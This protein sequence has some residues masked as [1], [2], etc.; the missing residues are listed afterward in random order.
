M[1]NTKKKNILMVIPWMEM[2]GADL[3]NLSIVEKLNKEMFSISIVCT[4]Q[5][6]NHWK[7]YFEKYVKDIHILP[8]ILEREE[9]SQY[10]LD[11][12]KKQNIDIVFLSNS[13]YGYHLLP[14]LKCTYPQVAVVDYVHMEEWYWRK[15]GYARLSGMLEYCVDQT[16]V[17]NQRTEKVLIDQFGRSPETV[18][19]LYIGVDQHRFDSSVVPRGEVR[20]K[21]NIPDDKKVI[22]FPCRIH[23][24][25]RPLLMLEIAKQVI[26][27]NENVCFFVAGDGPL[28]SELIKK[29]KR[30]KLNDWFICPGEI[31][32]MEKVYADS[33]L[34]L[35]CSLKEGLALTAYESC[36]MSTPV[37]S[38]DVGGQKELI[39]NT[40]GRLV[41]L[42][43]KETDIQTTEYSQEEI[44]AYTDAI[45]EVLED[46]VQYE[47]MCRNCRQKIETGF[48]TDQMI[49][50]LERILMD[51]WEMVQNSSQRER[52]PKS[53]M[54]WAQHYLETYLAYEEVLDPRGGSQ[55]INTELKRIAD[56]RL[57][58]IIIKV[59]L[60]L[61][62]NK[63]FR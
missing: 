24:Q 38:V 52:F 23:P 42:Y 60:K 31:T 4:I 5:G 3:F 43:Q 49:A 47:Q 30:Y 19:T 62:I 1:E 59:L 41:P 26:Q 45:L 13:Y 2:G 9:Y 37:V 57:G 20:G 63:L 40:V 27:R 53:M 8:E 25:K 35:I 50:S 29:L 10:V 55:S 51:T 28:Y 16:L 36:A 18:K 32:E 56:S 54:G 6:E 17:C 14:L 15:G 12:V 61:R 21:Y 33:D 11:L 58:R 48:S 46:P 39:D 34:T 44:C 7:H 22:L